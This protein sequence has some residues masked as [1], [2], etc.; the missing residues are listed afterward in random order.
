MQKL[1]GTSQSRHMILLAGLGWG[2]LILLAIPGGWVGHGGDVIGPG[3][4]FFAVF[5]GWVPFLLPALFGGL[6]LRLALRRRQFSKPITLLFSIMVFTLL[7]GIE[8]GVFAGSKYLSPSH[9]RSLAREAAWEVKPGEL[10][11]V[12]RHWT[13]EPYAVSFVSQLAALGKRR[14]GEFTRVDLGGR[15]IYK[16]NVDLDPR[17]RK[18]GN[19]TKLVEISARDTLYTEFLDAVLRPVHAFRGDMLRIDVSP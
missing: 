14:H 17:I 11:Q 10:T 5:L 4:L 16:T 13:K 18:I 8:Y 19:I 7:I 15:R 6:V 12:L 2:I 3:P 9:Q 1:Y